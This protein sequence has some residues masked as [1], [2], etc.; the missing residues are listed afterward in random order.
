MYALISIKLLICMSRFHWRYYN[1]TTYYSSCILPWRFYHYCI[2]CSS[3]LR[4]IY[5]IFTYSVCQVLSSK[6]CWNNPF[7]LAGRTIRLESSEMF[8]IMNKI[9][10]IYFYIPSERWVKLR[11]ILTLL[12][13]RVRTSVRTS[14]RT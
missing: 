2:F 1:S 14:I 7:F 11:D 4:I 5:K 10:F 8:W 9:D 6:Y 3:Q 13:F 12:F